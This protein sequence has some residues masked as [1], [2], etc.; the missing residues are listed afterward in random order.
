MCGLKEGSMN[1]LKGSEI[2]KFCA[3]WMQCGINVAINTKVRA[4]TS[5]QRYREAARRITT[6]SVELSSRSPAL[7]P[8]KTQAPESLGGLGFVQIT[9][10]NIP[11]PRSSLLGFFTSRS[12]S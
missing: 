1:F 5:I 2:F 7:K 6:L 9:D 11:V 3:Y 10:V 8:S 12:D 4:R